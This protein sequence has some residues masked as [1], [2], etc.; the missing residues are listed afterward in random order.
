[1]SSNIPPSPSSKR[2]RIMIITVDE[3]IINQIEKSNNVSLLEQIVL[4]SEGNNNKISNQ[5]STVQSSEK[6]NKPKSGSLIC[7]VCG[8]SANSYNFGAITC[9]SCKAFFRRNARKEF[10][11]LHCNGKGDCKITLETRRDCSACRLA[12]CFDSGMQCDRIVTVEQKA[13]KQRRIDEN[14]K[15]ALNSNSKMNEQECQLSASIFSDDL[16]TSVD[17][18]VLLTDFNDLLPSQLQRTLL[19]SEDLECIEAVSHSYQKR[20]EFAALDGLPWDPSMHTTTF[21]QILNSHSVAIMRLLSF[22]KQIPEF[23]QLN[24]DDKVILVKYNLITILGINCALSYNT[25]T[26]KIIEA[27]SDVPW[28]TQFFQ[29][30]HGYNMCMQSKKIFASFF[31]IVKYDRKIMELTLIIL[32]LTKSS[33]ITGDYDESIGND[34]MSVYRIQNY[35]TELLWKYMETMHGYEKAVDLFSKLMVH[36]ISWQTLQ[37]EMRKNIVRALSPED[38]SEL[39][40]IMKTVLRIS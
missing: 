29:V 21:V 32:I 19:N 13:E 34:T 26:D 5:Q 6:K 17:T 27:D 9:E 31:H 39:L 38:I 22:F 11:T 18:N 7:V 37:E 8:S 14:R 4:P 15:L 40:P 30:L 24:I 28:N 16:L 2:Q 25:E 10:T 33:A 3:S 36:V 35:Y 23:N 12:R 1:M 20:I